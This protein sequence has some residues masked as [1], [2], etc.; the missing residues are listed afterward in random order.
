MS[1]LPK[2]SERKPYYIT[3]FVCLALAAVLLLGSLVSSIVDSDSDYDGYSSS[4]TYVYTGSSTDGY[5]GDNVY[6]FSPYSSGTYEISFSY[7]SYNVENVVVKDSYGNTVYPS[8]N[9]YSTSYSSSYSDYSYYLNSYET[10][11]IEI[12]ADGYFTFSINR[13]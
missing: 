13:D 12:E 3:L 5:S 1:K 9:N 11:T 2:F 8:N 6:K 7:G 4:G 10:Y